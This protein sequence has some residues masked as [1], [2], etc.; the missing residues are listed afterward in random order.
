M[1]LTEEQRDNINELDVI[2]LCKSAENNYVG[3]GCG[4]LDQL[5]SN[6]GVKDCVLCLDSR[7]PMEELEIIQNRKLTFVVANTHK[8]HE[9]TDGKYVSRLA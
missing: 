1:F 4:I 7:Y 9:L 5:S 2:L 8:A 6:Q 3:M